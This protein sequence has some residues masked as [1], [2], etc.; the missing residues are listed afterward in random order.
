MILTRSYEEEA[1]A[2]ELLDNQ[3]ASRDLERKDFIRDL[4]ILRA[5]LAR[6]HDLHPPP[7]KILI[8]YVDEVLKTRKL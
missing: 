8:T 6:T 1:A 7:F 2:K 3:I 5:Q 4:E